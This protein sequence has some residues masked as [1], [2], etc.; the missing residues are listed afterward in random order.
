VTQSVTNCLHA[1]KGSSA[2]DA[3]MSL[4]LSDDISVSLPRAGLGPPLGQ[5][6]GRDAVILTIPFFRNSPCRV[7]IIVSRPTV[8][9]ECNFARWWRRVR[10]L[11]SASLFRYLNFYPPRH[12]AKE[13][14][15]MVV[16]SISLFSFRRFGPSFSVFLAPPTTSFMF[17]CGPH[18]LASVVPC[19][20]GYL[21]FTHFCGELR[22]LSSMAGATSRLLFFFCRFERRLCG[23]E[24]LFFPAFSSSTQF[25]FYSLCSGII[26]AWW[27]SRLHIL[28]SSSPYGGFASF[29]AFFYCPLADF[30]TGECG[31]FLSI[32]FPFAGQK[33]VSSLEGA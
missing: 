27:N 2:C 18:V 22:Q 17:L 7:L 25:I 23:L 21:L 19:R 8:K 15:P 31:S 5:F 24:T 14:V 4:S 29:Q 13:F 20:P 6:R 26:E 3:L 33:G 28:H 1:V 9:S 32:S 30:L 12:L 11:A 16:R 10:L